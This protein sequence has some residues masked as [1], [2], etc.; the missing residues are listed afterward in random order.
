VT[1]HRPIWRVIEQASAL[2]GVQLRRIFALLIPFWAV[3]V[4]ATVRESQSYEVFDK[5]LSRAIAEAQLNTSSDLAAFFGVDGALVERSLSF[6]ETIGHVRRSGASAS[7]TELGFCSVHDGVRYVVKEDRQYLYFDAFRSM[8]MPRS[9]YSGTEWLD[10]PRLSMPG[11]GAF[12]VISAA[13]AELRTDAVEALVRRDDREQFNVPR[14]L[15]DIKVRS[16]GTVFLPI[17]A[18][19]SRPAPLIYSMAIDGV[20][21]Y[22]SRLLR[23]P[24]EELFAA[25]PPLDD[26]AIWR[27]YLDGLGFQDVRP[28]RMSNGVLRAVIPDAAAGT[29]LKWHKIG[30]FEHRD[31]SFLQLWCAGPG[32]RRRAVLTRVSNMVRAGLAR[33]VDEV[34]NRLS[35]V[36]HQLEVNPP[37]VEELRRHATRYG[38]EAAVAALNLM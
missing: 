7:L 29:T 14:G 32:V 25:E 11:Q 9:H 15:H 17:Y 30:S 8:P 2:S 24:L 21:A 12:Q 28:T 35:A 1:A 37:T 4:S 38:D 27:R 20:D 16:V 19:D 13:A 22:L 3:E 34:E 31:R 26:M 10:E 5:Y 36:A 23:Q 18:I 6:L 33:A